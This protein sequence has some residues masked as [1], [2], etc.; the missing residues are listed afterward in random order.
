LDKKLTTSSD[1]ITADTK[2]NSDRITANASKTT[3]TDITNKPI[4]TTV[5]V[6]F[7]SNYDRHIHHVISRRSFTAAVIAAAIV[8]YRIGNVVLVHVV[9]SGGWQWQQ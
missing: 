6:F 5:I 3:S 8:E 4:T 9:T 1:R 7:N 2:G